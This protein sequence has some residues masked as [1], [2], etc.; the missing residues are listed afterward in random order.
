MANL[1]PAEYL[2]HAEARLAAERARAAQLLE[3]ATAP[4]LLA[5]VHAQ[6][7]TPHLAGLIAAG[8]PGMLAAAVAPA[9]GAGD[10]PPGHADLARLHRL[11]RALAPSCCARSAVLRGGRPCVELIPALS[12]QIRMCM[13]GSAHAAQATAVWGAPSCDA[14]AFTCNP[15]VLQS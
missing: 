5:A 13:A 8:L 2:A 12:R 6:L 7:L 11:S 9:A 10:G 3:H 15:G 1:L 14:N 4:P